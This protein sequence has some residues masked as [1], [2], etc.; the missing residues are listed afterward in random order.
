MLITRKKKQILMCPPT[1]FEVCY[2]IN[3]DMKETLEHGR[4]V[5][6]KKAMR[7]WEGLRDIYTSEGYECVYIEPIRG[8]PDMVFTANAGLVDNESIIIGKFKYRERQK[9]TDYFYKW[10]SDQAYKIIKIPYDFEGGGDA[11]IWQR[12]VIGGHGF[13]SDPKGIEVAAS[14]IKKEAVL[15]KLVDPRFYHLDTCFAPMEERALFY[16]KA[17]TVASCHALE[18]LGEVI[19]IDEKD[20]LRRGCNG[21]YLKGKSNPKYVVNDVSQTLEK[22]LEKLVIEAIF[23]ETSEFEKSGGSNRC[24]SLFL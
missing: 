13:R 11:L 16:P 19:P 3:P 18:K 6:K 17:F 9:E 1:Y 7:Q 8:L 14:L 20:A 15:L 22:K 12:K 21:V 10:F 23:N 5:N 24:L 2:N 4:K